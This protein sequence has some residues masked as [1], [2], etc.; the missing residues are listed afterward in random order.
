MFSAIVDRS[1]CTKA[2]FRQLIASLLPEQ[3]R[4]QLV[5][6]EAHEF[7]PPFYDTLAWRLNAA[8]LLYGEQYPEGCSDS[9]AREMWFIGMRGEL[10]VG[11]IVYRLWDTLHEALQSELLEESPDFNSFMALP[12]WWSNADVKIS[13]PMYLAT[14][15]LT[16]DTL[17]WVMHAWVPES[18]RPRAY[19]TLENAFPWERHV[20]G[21]A[22]RS[23][24]SPIMPTNA[25]CGLDV[26]FGEAFD[27]LLP[28]Q[29]AYIIPIN[30]PFAEVLARRQALN[31]T[32]T[33]PRFT[34][35]PQ[36]HAMRKTLT[37]TKWGVDVAH[38]WFM[39]AT[40]TTV[41]L[42]AELNKHR[43][44]HCSLTQN[45]NDSA[46][47][48]LLEAGQL[49]TRQYPDG[50]PVDRVRLEWVSGMQAEL[51]FFNADL[52]HDAA[53][54]P[55]NWTLVVE[56]L[57]GCPEFAK[58]ISNPFLQLPQWFASP[59]VSQGVN[60]FLARVGLTSASI[61][62]VCVRGVPDTFRPHVASNPRTAFPRECDL[63]T[64]QWCTENP[65][66]VSVGDYDWN[67]YVPSPFQAHK[68][69]VSQQADILRGL[70]LTPESMPN[71]TSH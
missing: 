50:C 28:D 59:H 6:V 45:P 71:S 60:E 38:T 1:H 53:R 31:A 14:V 44:L 7:L 11:N 17:A 3:D 61:K 2:S 67:E 66:W 36:L 41:T 47:A 37:V 58:T 42:L 34:D 22:W 57:T 15:S 55:A 10:T 30:T 35:G 9:L 68:Q 16:S 20:L 29:Q 56:A 33:L 48:M 40:Q 12:H 69:A 27:A 46:E 52:V 49:Y 13:V 65:Q 19:L 39:E 43:Q 63:M 24:H 8:A 54:I 26:L 23:T 32:Y 18:V 51:F 70:G 62:W 4:D 5:T 64:Q 25:D 21:N